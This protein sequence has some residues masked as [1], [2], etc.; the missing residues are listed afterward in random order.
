MMPS[1]I[2]KIESSM[3]LM[4]SS[5]HAEVPSTPEPPRLTL[6][7]SA[8]YRVTAAAGVEPGHFWRCHYSADE[9]R[10][11]QRVASDGEHAA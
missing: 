5:L 2:G 3:P 6:C 10:N 7:A 9:L 8:V 11:L 1:S 4:A